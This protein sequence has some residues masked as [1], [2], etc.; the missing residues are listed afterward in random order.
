[1]ILALEK[2]WLLSGSMEGH[3]V[4]VFL[5]CCLRPRLV[6]IPPLVFLEEG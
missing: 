5:G 2:S 6:W 4:R 3:Y 1:M